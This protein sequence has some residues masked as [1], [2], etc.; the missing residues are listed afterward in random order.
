MI[1]TL[2]SFLHF[3]S[4]ALALA[5]AAMGFDGEAF[6]QTAY[7]AE[8]QRLALLA[9]FL[10]GVSQALGHAV[11][12][13]LNRVSALRFALSLLLTGIIFAAGVLITALS[14]VVASDLLLGASAPFAAVAGVVALA[15]APRLLG[16]LMF[17]P[18]FGE[19]L[20]SVL[21][22]WVLVLMIFGLASGFNVSIFIVLAVVVASWVLLRIIRV[23][24]GGP[25]ARLLDVLRDAAAGQPLA[26]TP[27]N[28]IAFL[29]TR[30]RETRNWWKREK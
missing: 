13:F 10:A 6:R 7:T 9:A 17:A 11:V 8:A 19:L 20:D 23:F 15:Q 28:V 18:Y 29:E 16:V 25:I 1:E 22:A 24:L 21:D 14:M 26:L 5:W 2:F 30:A 12:L 3:I 27:A 4:D